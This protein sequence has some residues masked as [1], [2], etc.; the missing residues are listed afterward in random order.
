MEHFTALNV[1]H[2]DIISS[3]FL[4]ICFLLWK[5][6]PLQRIDMSLKAN[7]NVTIRDTQLYS[8][9]WGSGFKEPLQ[10]DGQKGMEDTILILGK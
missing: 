1:V 10:E 4:F 6:W 2:W 7:C 8:T 3:G 5:H 9:G